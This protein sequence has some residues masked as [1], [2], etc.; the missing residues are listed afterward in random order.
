MHF[1]M[2]GCLGVL[3]GSLHFSVGKR[4]LERPLEGMQHHGRPLIVFLCFSSRLNKPEE[5]LEFIKAHLLNVSWN[6]QGV[7]EH[8]VP[9][10]SF[11]LNA[12]KESMKI[13]YCTNCY[14][15][16]YLFLKT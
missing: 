15:A 14:L 7:S 12:P 6:L 1:K 5:R 4:P 2:P 9:L 13:K 10:F 8:I 3:H 11:S 16:V